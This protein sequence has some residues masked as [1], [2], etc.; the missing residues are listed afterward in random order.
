[1]IPQALIKPLALQSAR[2][3]RESDGTILTAE[4]REKLDI[5]VTMLVTGQDEEI[6]GAN[7]RL[8]CSDPARTHCRDSYKFFAAGRDLRLRR[9]TTAGAADGPPI[10]QELRQPVLGPA[11]G[12]GRG[13]Y[14]SHQ[15][16]A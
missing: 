4:W 2:Q 8:G 13:R 16:T 3:R 7:P 11:G 1:M 6:C 15:H 5:E 10:H 14:A 12:G 9:G